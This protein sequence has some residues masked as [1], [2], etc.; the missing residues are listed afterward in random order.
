ML[1]D[2]VAARDALK[3]SGSCI[4]RNG[5]NGSLFNTLTAAPGRLSSITINLSAFTGGRT[6]AGYGT[7]LVALSSIPPL[8]ISDPYP[9]LVPG[10]EGGT[11]LDWT[12][13]GEASSCSLI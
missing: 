7:K 11:P 5:E 6:E 10:V 4:S 8:I 3:R 9:I 13:V 12:L 2:K 1:G